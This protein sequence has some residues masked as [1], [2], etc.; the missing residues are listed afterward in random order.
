MEVSQETIE[1]VLPSTRGTRIHLTLSDK[2]L[3]VVLDRCLTNDTSEDLTDS[4]VR[5][6][7]RVGPLGT[8]PLCAGVEGVRGLVVGETEGR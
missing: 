5:R 2:I 6:G 1:T 3:S 8:K 7:P 4:P